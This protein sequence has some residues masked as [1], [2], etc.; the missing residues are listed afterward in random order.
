ELCPHIDINRFG[1][2]DVGRHANQRSHT[3]Y[4]AASALVIGAAPA[5]SMLMTGGCVITVWNSCSNARTNPVMPKLA[6]MCEC[7]SCIA[8]IC[9]P[10]GRSVPSAASAVQNGAMPT[11]S[12]F[13]LTKL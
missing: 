3:V 1:A 11:P 8:T 7:A 2:V 5:C 10:C 9:E 12:E 13:A 6:R 4:C